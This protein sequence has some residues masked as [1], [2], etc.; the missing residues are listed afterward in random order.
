MKEN[1]FILDGAFLKNSTH[2]IAG[3]T[4]AQTRY[5]I[6]YGKSIVHDWTEI[7]YLNFTPTEPSAVVNDVEY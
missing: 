5:I 1:D 6:N 7:K 3:I 4:C 2:S